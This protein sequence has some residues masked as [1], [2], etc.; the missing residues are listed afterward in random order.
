MHFP[1]FSY[2]F[3]KIVFLV[4]NMYN[5]YIIMEYLVNLKLVKIKKKF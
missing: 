2:H 5:I 4:S 3:G 1:R